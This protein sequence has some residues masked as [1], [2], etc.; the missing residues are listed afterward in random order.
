MDSQDLVKIGSRA[1]NETEA[2][3]NRHLNN[4][5]KGWPKNYLRGEAYTQYLQEQ[6]A[7]RGGSVRIFIT[8]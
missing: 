3:I 8:Q 5:S 7:A 1:K 6:K 4:R 2:F